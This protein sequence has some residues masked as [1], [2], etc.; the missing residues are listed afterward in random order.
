[1]PLQK[2][3]DS[4]DCNHARYGTTPRCCTYEAGCV[5]CNALN[6]RTLETD[7][8]QYDQELFLKCNFS[9]DHVSSI[10]DSAVKLSRSEED[11]WHSLQP[12]GVQFED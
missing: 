7:N 10:D 3:A 6:T 12:L 4:K 1:M 2:G 5:A 9:I 8:I 11:D